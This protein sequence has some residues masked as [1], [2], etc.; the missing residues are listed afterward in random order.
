ML[1]SR[2]GAFSLLAHTLLVAAALRATTTAPVARSPAPHRLIYVASPTPTAPA[3]A[4]TGATPA[5]PD[6]PPIAG[7]A[8][9]WSPPVLPRLDL[10]GPAGR[11]FDPRDFLRAGGD[12][13]PDGAANGPHDLGS[14]GSQ[15]LTAD[16]VDDPAAPVAQRPPDYPEALRLTGAG[17]AVMLEFVVDT[18]G[19]VE[20]ATFRTV[21]AANPALVDAVRQA[22][23]AWRFRP[24]RRAGVAVRQLVRQRFAFAPER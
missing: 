18:A 21:G 22:A 7:P 23:P 16:V 6:A 14:P 20:L 11:A 17:G 8:P 12:G 15:V 13:R 1:A 19:R 4:T 9:A 24:A 10:A 5:P 3:G 2:A